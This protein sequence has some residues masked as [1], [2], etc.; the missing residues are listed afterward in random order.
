MNTKIT[1]KKWL[2]A[3]T[4]AILG[5]FAFPANADHN[6][7]HGGGDDGGSG[8][9]PDVLLGAWL[10]RW[11]SSSLISGFESRVTQRHT[12]I[13]NMFISFDHTWQDIQRNVDPVYDNGSIIMLTWEPAGLT[14]VDISSGAHDAYLYQMAQN[15]RD[16][17]SGVEIWV[18]PMHEMNG[19]WYSWGV[20]DSAVNTNETFITA[21]RHIHEIFQSANA[22]NVKFV[23]N[24]NHHP[25]GAG[26]DYVGSYPGDAYVDYAGMDGYNW[27][28]S[29]SWSTW[30]SF[31]STFKMA[32]DAI[33]AATTKPIVIGEWASAEK[34][35]DKAAW[36]TDAFN[37]IKSGDWPQIEVL[38]WFHERKEAAW[39]ID[40]SSASLD[41]YRA[42]TNN[43]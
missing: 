26:A 43:W 39:Q 5:A 4:F 23:W 29:Q 11:P 19:N 35:G 13:V 22:G 31:Y 41:A 3:L 34:G 9:E 21:W 17:R 16:Y 42:A 38:V 6:P 1:S 2:L 36:I 25:V 30:T 27:G 14:T 18:R 24:I 40:S 15:M 37:E 10:G 20:G 8:V 12:D 28:T 7:N 32:Y 33:T